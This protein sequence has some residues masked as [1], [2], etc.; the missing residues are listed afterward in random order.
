MRYSLILAACL[1]TPSAA[2]ELP[3]AIPEVQA[4]FQKTYDT[5]LGLRV[6]S[7]DN[8]EVFAEAQKI[9]QL[10][11]DEQTIE[12][13]AVFVANTESVEDTHTI[14]SLVLWRY[15]NVPTVTTMR[16]LAPFLDAEDRSLRGFVDDWF[17]GHHDSED[18]RQYMR[19]RTAVPAPFIKFLYERSPGEA[20]LLMQAGSVDVAADVQAAIKQLEGTGQ[21]AARKPDEGRREILLAEHIVSNALWLHKNGFDERFQAVLPEAMAELEKLSKSEKWWARMYVAYIMGRNTV[22]L[23]DHILRQLAEDENELVREAATAGRGR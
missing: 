3:D 15:L 21:G 13:L 22:L 6:M 1:C 10:V 12:Q 16:V 20:L 2:Q 9:K 18:F 17:E 11:N 4:Q 7:F 8:A 19:G 5:M 23:Q 14:M